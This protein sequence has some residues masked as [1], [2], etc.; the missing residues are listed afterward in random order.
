MFLFSIL[1]GVEQELEE[2]DIV[3]NY[4]DYEDKEEEE[5]NQEEDEMACSPAAVAG[6]GAAGRGSAAG[7]LPTMPAFLVLFAM[8]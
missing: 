2:E 4:E 5:D 1:T 7:N 3:D 6:R 8:V